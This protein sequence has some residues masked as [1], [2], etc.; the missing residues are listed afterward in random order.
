M[1]WNYTNNRPLNSI[2][3]LSISPDYFREEFDEWFEQESDKGVYNEDDLQSVRSAI[4]NVGYNLHDFML[5][6][7]YNMIPNIKLREYF[8]VYMCLGTSPSSKFIL[9][10]TKEFEV[11]E[12]VDILYK[13]KDMRWG[14][15]KSVSNF[16]IYC[17]YYFCE[18]EED[19]W[20]IFADGCG[21]IHKLSSYYYDKDKEK[22]RKALNYILNNENKYLKAAT[23]KG[24]QT[25]PQSVKDEI[26]SI[27]K[28]DFPNN[29]EAN[30]LDKNI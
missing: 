4:D 26:I 6:H 7:A 28:N 24:Y 13:A 11:L 5:T 12:G 23:G 22:E 15:Q 16:D 9:Y 27:L 18:T 20:D 8:I 30:I 3:E 21:D 1:I 29:L 14:S 25:C 10:D 2:R 19:I 17:R